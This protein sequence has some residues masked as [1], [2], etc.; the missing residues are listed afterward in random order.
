MK[1]SSGVSEIAL[2]S[3]TNATKTD[4]VYLWPKYTDGKVEK[5]REVRGRSEDGVF[6]TKPTEQERER[7]LSMTK[8]FSH[9]EYRGNGSLTQSKAVLKPGT[10]FNA[11]A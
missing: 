5:V 11:L 4:K 2:Q 7:L 9:D 8:E 3:M 1:I 6:Y 10:F